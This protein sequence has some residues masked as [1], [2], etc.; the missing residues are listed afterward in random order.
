[1]A[2]TD[3]SFNI[4]GSTKDKIKAK[5][6]GKNAREKRV[7]DVKGD[8]K[9]AI[10]AALDNYVDVDEPDMYDFSSKTK[11]SPKKK[12]SMKVSSTRRED[13]GVS[14]HTAV[15]AQRSVKKTSDG[16]A[17]SDH[18]L[19][20]RKKEIKR[21]SN[22]DGDKQSTTP[23]LGESP[24]MLGMMLDSMAGGK[25]KKTGARSVASMPVPRTRSGRRA[26][27]RSEDGEVE[28]DEVQEGGQG[29]PTRERRRRASSK[30]AFDDSHLPS[31]SEAMS[32]E[33]VSR[34]GDNTGMLGK[35]L[36]VS[37]GKKKKK[38][39]S[40]SVASMPADVRATAAHAK[41]SGVERSTSSRTSERPRREG[42]PTKPRRTKSSDG[43]GIAMVE[44]HDSERGGGRGASHDHDQAKTKKEAPPSD[45]NPV[46]RHHSMTPTPTVTAPPPKREMPAPMR[47]AS[48]M[49]NREA[50]RRGGKGQSLANV[51]QEYSEEELP[52]TSYFASNHILVNR[53]RM[54]RGL[55]PLNRNRA[56]DDLAREHAAKMA[57]SSGKAPLATTFVGNVLRGA[58]IR[59]IHRATMIERDGRERYNILNPYFQEFGVGTAK[60]QD[61]ML[62]MCQLFSESISLTCTDAILDD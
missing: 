25:P 9:K 54:K 45:R 46:R 7:S 1:M 23:D 16:L 37:A 43:D 42:A 29:S 58:S 15:K 18:G 40:R 41:R 36:E 20:A 32:P 6:D 24:G 35:M 21:K 2:N 19:G 5:L 61:G 34:P 26:R 8:R 62:Y 14:E 50:T 11:S 31:T 55:R 52:S 56:M 17:Q 22:G 57:S 27:L 48:M 12:P 38:V 28:E 44:L 4:N 3:V 30:D 51:T 53:E 47:S 49:L 13:L 33:L 10:G 39:G 60:G 59:A